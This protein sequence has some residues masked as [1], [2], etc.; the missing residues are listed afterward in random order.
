M[1]SFV[2]R[3]SG[4]VYNDFIYDK[5]G[6]GFLVVTESVRGGGTL[7]LFD[8]SLGGAKVF[9]KILPRLVGIGEGLPYA[10]VIG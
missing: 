1:T 9:L 7:A 4:A 3:R 2:S 10:D 5:C 6:I 8:V